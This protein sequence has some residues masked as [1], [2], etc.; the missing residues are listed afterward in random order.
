MT[1]NR[2]CA[3]IN[4]EIEK[5]IDTMTKTDFFKRELDLI[6]NEDLRMAVKSYLEESVPSIFGKSVL[7]L[8][9]S[10]IRLFPRVSAVLF[11]TLRRL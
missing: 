1:S 2:K 4:T 8:P 7:L 6:V 9:A 11:A 10:S 3:I 5:G